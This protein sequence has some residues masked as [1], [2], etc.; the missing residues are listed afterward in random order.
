MNRVFI[1]KEERKEGFEFPTYNFYQAYEGFRKLGFHP[2]FFNTELPDTLTRY[3]V[4][5][6]YITGVKKSIAKLGIEPPIEIDYPEELNAYYGRKLWKSD[7][8]HI[9]NH[10]E[11]FPV[12]IKPVTG[13]QFDG[14]LV[15]GFVDLIGCGEQSY[16]PDIWCSEPVKFITEWRVFVRYKKVVDARHYKGSPF[17]QLDETTVKNCINDFTN[18]PAGCSMDFGLTDDGR[19]L[20][21]E[22]NDGY[23]LGNYGLLDVFYA[24]LMYARWCEM[25]DIPDDLNYF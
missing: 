15:K 24:K 25:V 5:V 20:L 2:I 14:R 23:S 8:D 16:S 3:D 10:P 1:R 4:V 17:S 21:I 19:C 12:F 6:D 7:V 11:L 22:V 9:A 13:K 18:I